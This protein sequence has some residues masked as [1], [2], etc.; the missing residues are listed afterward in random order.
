[1]GL[2]TWLSGC[3]SP[4]HLELAADVYKFDYQRVKNK[5]R[6]F[7]SLRKKKKSENL[8][9]LALPST[10]GKN[11]CALPFAAVPTT[12]CGLTAQSQPFTRF[13]LTWP[14]QA[15]EGAAPTPVQ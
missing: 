12:P 1:M 8:A 3:Y 14:L 15:A 10:R 9:T 2:V 5:V 11:T 4:L 6:S 7:A 13:H